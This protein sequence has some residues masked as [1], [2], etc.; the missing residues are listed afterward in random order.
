MAH[1]IGI[2]GKRGVGKSLLCNPYLKMRGFEVL[3]FA[4][5]LK[6]DVRKFYRL[7][8][9]HTDGKL[10]ESPCQRLGG[11]TPREAMIAEG[12]LRREF[13]ESGLFWVN[14]L[15]DE[16]I[17]TLPEDSL[18]AIS[19]VRFKNEAEFIRRHGGAII[20]LE[21]SAELNIYKTVI[22]D[23]SETE[24]DDY[25]FDKVLPADKNITPQDLERFAD[26]VEKW[27]RSVKV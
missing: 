5:P 22:D 12:K 23:P 19:D 25:R 4:D 7:T 27:V 21:R 11:R 9:D 1:V 8:K 16:K 13:S 18:V 20:R 10:K 3:A 6:E 14:K 17:K 15:Y 24:L 2:S 26:E